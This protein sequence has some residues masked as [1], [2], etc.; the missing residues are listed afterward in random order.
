MGARSKTFTEH[1]YA[2]RS[3]AT[4]DFL[5]LLATVLGTPAIIAS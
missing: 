4:K 5:V 3:F 1:C 2:L